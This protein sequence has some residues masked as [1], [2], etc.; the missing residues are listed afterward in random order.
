M[1]IKFLTS[2]AGAD[3]SFQI[4]QEYEVDDEWARALISS[5]IAEEV[6]PD[7]KQDL[8]SAGDRAGDTGG[9]QRVSATRRNRSR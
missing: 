2:L 9:S 1:K 6:L 3:F 4:R 5:G 7:G 8:Q